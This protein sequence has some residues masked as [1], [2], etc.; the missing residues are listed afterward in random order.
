MPFSPHLRRPLLLLTILRHSNVSK[1][2]EL[3]FECISF[4]LRPLICFAT[5]YSGGS[6]GSGADLSR[7]PGQLICVTLRSELP[8][9]LS[10]SIEWA[11]HASYVQVIMFM[12][13][14]LCAGC[15]I[16]GM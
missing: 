7:A 10:G 11:V 16:F 12:T 9:T 4:A 3:L 5:G 15:T 6:G 8:L 14:Y 1:R 2:N 13:P